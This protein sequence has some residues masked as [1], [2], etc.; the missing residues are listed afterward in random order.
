MWFASVSNGWLP[1]FG[2]TAYGLIAVAVLYV[3]RRESA[4]ITGIGEN[5]HSFGPAISLW[6]AAADFSRQTAA[7]LLIAVIIVC[8]FARV[9][10]GGWNHQDAIVVVIAVATWPVQEWLVH[11][12]LLHL[13]PFT[14]AG[15]KIDLLIAIQHRAHHTN[16]WNPSLGLTPAFIIL[17]YVVGFMPM[18]MWLM[19][20]GPALTL[21]ITFFGLVLNY[22]WLH[23]LIHTSYVPRSSIYKRLWRNTQPL[24]K[25]TPRSDSCLNIA[26]DEEANTQTGA[27]RID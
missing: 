16:P 13:R 5:P 9:Y 2:W 20:T 8:C 27:E 25:Q 12:L 21:A 14:I 3:M 7:R 11:V 18:W 6:R 17:G 26:K 1:I 23:Y 24:P 15:R 22:E 19:P 4:R 10:V